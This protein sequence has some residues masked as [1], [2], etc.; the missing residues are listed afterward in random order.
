M[1]ERVSVWDVCECVC[2]LVF[3]PN[4]VSINACYDS[5]ELVWGVSALLQCLYH[6]HLSSFLRDP[7]A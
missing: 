1:G 4:G 7:L 5:Q 2:V 3:F 6:P